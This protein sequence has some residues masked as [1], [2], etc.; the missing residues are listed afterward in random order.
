M[1]LIVHISVWK[2]FKYESISSKKNKG[3]GSKTG[4]GFRRFGVL[5]ERGGE[6]GVYLV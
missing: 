4:Q 1:R 6:K 5:M 3:I 2:W